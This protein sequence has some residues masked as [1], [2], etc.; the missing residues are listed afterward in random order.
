M[1][2]SLIYLKTFLDI[3]TNLNIR[4]SMGINWIKL[5]VF[6]FDDEKI[7]LIRRTR[8]GDETVL[9]F[10][11]LLTFAG[12]EGSDTIN[13]SVDQLS[14]LTQKTKNF[15]RKAIEILINFG[16][17]SV[18]F[19]SDSC[20][21]PV[22]FLSDSCKIFPVFIKNFAKYQN[23]TELENLRKTNR[24]RVARHRDK[25]KCNVTR[26][27]CNATDKNK[28]K[29]KIIEEEY[30]TPLTPQKNDEKSESEKNFIK[31]EIITLKEAVKARFESL[32]Y[33][34]ANIYGFELDHIYEEAIKTYT[35]EI[36]L[37]AISLWN[38]NERFH[39]TIVRGYT[40][41]LNKLMEWFQRRNA[42]DNSCS[43]QKTVK[44]D[45]L[46]VET[47]SPEMQKFLEE[48]YKEYM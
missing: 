36:L 40:I 10:I 14:I 12:K 43:T 23:L 13:Y 15:C 8:N 29:N 7:K 47:R 5:N 20:Q 45:N 22:E 44:Y 2:N 1:N 38:N 48:N 4:G 33:K 16:L 3:A 9:F 25:K 30:I 46:T 35:L 17:I 6:I 11:Q 37:Q 27:E 31:N 32:S 42:K 18:E 19:S 28:N 41:D 34:T 21:I 26:N 24:D 39:P